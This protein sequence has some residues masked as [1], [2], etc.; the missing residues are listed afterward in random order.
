MHITKRT[1]SFRDWC[2][3]TKKTSVIAGYPSSFQNMLKIM[4]DIIPNF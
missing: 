4:H 3:D 2:N 1:H